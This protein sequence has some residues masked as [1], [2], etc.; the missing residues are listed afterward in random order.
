VQFQGLKSSSFVVVRKTEGGWKGFP[1]ANSTFSFNRSDEERS[2]ILWH[3]AKYH[4]KKN[5]SIKSEHC[6]TLADMLSMKDDDEKTIEDKDIT[7][8]VVEKNRY[9][10]QPSGVIPQGFLRVWDGTGYPPSDP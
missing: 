7:V 2:Q 10:A 5:P 1:S 6:F 8:M 3:W 4:L 9:S